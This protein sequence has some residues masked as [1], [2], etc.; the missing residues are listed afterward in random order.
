MMIA[1]SIAGRKAMAPAA[2]IALLLNTGID[3][4][5]YISADMLNVTDAM[6]ADALVGLQIPAS[7]L[8]V[9]SEMFFNVADIP[10][11]VDALAELGVTFSNGTGGVASTAMQFAP[12]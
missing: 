4:T 3:T 8:M 10:T 11:T 6:L 9:G 7:G 5:S 1:N 2:I 12:F